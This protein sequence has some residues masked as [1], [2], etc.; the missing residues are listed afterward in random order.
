MLNSVIL[1]D[2]IMCRNL[3]AINTS[4]FV[5]DSMTHCN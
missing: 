2:I 3:R 1:A 4:V 5:S